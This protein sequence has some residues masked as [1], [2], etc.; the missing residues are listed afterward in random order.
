MVR[1]ECHSNISARTKSSKTSAI[2]HVYAL[3]N[4][5]SMGGNHQV[6]KILIKHAAWTA[7]TRNSAA[8]TTQDFTAS[9]GP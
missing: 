5:D 9:G 1:K 2:P 8:L 3:L 6:T 4:E 7:L